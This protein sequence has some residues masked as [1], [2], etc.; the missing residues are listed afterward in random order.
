MTALK[1]RVLKCLQSLK[2]FRNLKRKQ[3]VAYITDTVLMETNKP[4]LQTLLR[5]E[6]F[7]QQ[8]ASGCVLS[9]KW[10]QKQ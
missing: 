10:M 5:R 7:F 6:Q 9:A 2:K 4:E 1:P 8:G 3:P